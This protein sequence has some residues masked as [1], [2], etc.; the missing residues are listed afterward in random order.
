LPFSFSSGGGLPFSS[1][2]GLPFPFPFVVEDAST[3]LF[4]L[5]F[6][7][8]AGFADGADGPGGGALLKAA[9]PSA[10][11]KDDGLAASLLLLLPLSRDNTRGDTELSLSSSTCKVNVL[12]LFLLLLSGC[13]LYDFFNAERSRW[14]GGIIASKPRPFPLP[15]PALRNAS[16]CIAGF[17]V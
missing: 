5:E 12:V 7:G 11:N 10:G 16:S 14:G 17:T 8:D 4:L 3:S 13:G 15:L 9:L 6:A 1:G 2:G